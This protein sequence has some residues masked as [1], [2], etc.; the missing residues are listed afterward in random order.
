M[1]GQGQAKNSEWAQF[2]Y[3]AYG[4]DVGEL[5]RTGIT[6]NEKKSGEEYSK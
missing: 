1:H 4:M 6:L 2:Q 3:F 5:K